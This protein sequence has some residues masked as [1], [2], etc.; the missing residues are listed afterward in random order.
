MIEVQNVLV[1][2]TG[3]TI[4]MIID[5]ESQSLIPIDFEQIYKHIPVLES[6]NVKID[7]VSMDEI[8]DSSDMN[9]AFWVKL[10]DIIEKNYLNYDGFVVLHGSDTM[11]Y[12]AS[13]LSFMLENLSKPVILT[14]SQLPLGMVRSDG[15][16]NFINA[17]E[18]ASAYEDETPLLPEVAV[19]FE[20][21]LF[22]GNRTSKF[23]A[24]HFDAFISGNYPTLA[25]VGVRIKYNTTYIR[26]PAYKKLKVHKNL[27][28]AVGILK[29]FPGIP[30]NYVKT[31]LNQDD[32]EIVILESY[33]AGNAPTNK[34]FLTLIEAALQKDKIILNISQCKSGE[35]EMGL[36][37]ASRKMLELGVIS[38]RDMTAEAALTKSMYLLGEGYRGEDLK[39][40]LQKSLRGEISD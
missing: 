39:K 22:R 40:L 6:M 30:L 38:G 13:M 24:E 21:K 7:H 5:E 1:I 3:G 20:N 18:I 14:G 23:N 28:N 15:R 8:I 16:E 19:F 36:Y 10:V 34:A 17:V 32:L 2:Y 12:T 31:I 37:A 25:E 33:G 29:L 26:K 27:S 35:V 9:P 11:A 4:G